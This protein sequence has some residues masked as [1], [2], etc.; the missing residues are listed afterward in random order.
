MSVTVS[1]KELLNL[2]QT[3]LSI[4]EAGNWDEVAKLEGQRQALVRRLEAALN[5]T[6]VETS[7][8]AIE[9]DLR[10]VLSINK[11]MLAL[12]EQVRSDLAGSMN[13]LR[14][15]RKAVNAYYGMK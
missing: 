5:A 1:S 15:G 6:G 11:H 2:T 12:G 13:G 8:Y 14:Q 3:M 7:I 9:N 10:E 4:A